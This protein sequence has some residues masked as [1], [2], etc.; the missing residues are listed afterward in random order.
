MSKGKQARFHVKARETVLKRGLMD[1]CITGQYRHFVGGEGILTDERF[2]FGADLQTGEYLSFEIP[3]AEIYA[4]DKIGV[5]FF[6]R[7]ML[8]TTDGKQY[9]LN[10]FFVGR[11]VK[12]LRRAAAAAKEKAAERG[13]GKGGV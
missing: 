2:F 1:Y 9:R 7:S 11:W 13:E 4:V 5:P 10:A 3:L 12:P 6:T 8:V